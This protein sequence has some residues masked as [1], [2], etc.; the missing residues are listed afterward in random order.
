MP[1]LV[2]NWPSRSRYS[3]GSPLKLPIF[4]K[5]LHSGGELLSCQ[6]GGFFCQRRIQAGYLVRQ[7]YM[8][9]A[10]APGGGQVSI[11]V[12]GMLASSTYHMRAQVQLSNGTTV[13][14]QD[15]VFETGALPQSVL[16]AL[17]VT[18]R[19]ECE[20]RGGTD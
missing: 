16:P 20:S 1:R 12:A 3:R 6:S 18:C 14:D 5:V 15:H 9:C 13:Y 11:L 19:A 10:S 8:G 17:T 2:M 4:K 7:L